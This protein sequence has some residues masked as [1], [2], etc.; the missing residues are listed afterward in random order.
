M[1]T[2]FYRALCF[3]LVLSINEFVMLNISQYY[4]YINE[5]KL[6]ILQALYSTTE[7]EI[8]QRVVVARKFLFSFRLLISRFRLINS[9]IDK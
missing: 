5:I 7:I 8:I 6:N 4:L 2:Q 3:T 9:Q 1:T